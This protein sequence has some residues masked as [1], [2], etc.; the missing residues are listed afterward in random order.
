[1]HR[2]SARYSRLLSAIPLA[3]CA[4][5]LGL[6]AG[7]V[8]ASEPT[9]LEEGGSFDVRSAYLEPSDHVYHLNATLDLA[10]SRAASQA[11][12]DGVPVV[13]ELDLDIDR[14]RRLLPDV[15]VGS[16]VQRWQVSYHALSER[17]LVNNLN[18]GE[19][20]SYG[21]LAAALAALSDVRRLPVIDES[22][23]SSG[24]HYEAS[25]RIVASIEG[26]LPS[27]LKTMMFWMDWKRTSEW[28]TWTVRL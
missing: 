26:G 20:V 12:T 21:S 15:R 9:T 5:L 6:I 3:V 24:S 17:Y 22:L 13:I 19:Q 8:F 7:N 16:L 27:A 18:S 1:M 4:L 10:L 14:R 2:S 11:L 28:Y 25:V 23:L